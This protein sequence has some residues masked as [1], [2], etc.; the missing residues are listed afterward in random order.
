VLLV[1]AGELEVALDDGAVEGVWLEDVPDA[2]LPLEHPATPATTVAAATASINSRF[3]A[4][5]FG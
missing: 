3:T 1:G 4:I 5:S 2:L